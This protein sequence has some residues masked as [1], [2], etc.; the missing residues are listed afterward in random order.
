MA[1][2]IG[3][4]DHR[5]DPGGLERLIVVDLE[6]PGGPAGMTDEAAINRGEDVAGVGRQEAEQVLAVDLQGV[7]AEL[8]DRAA[9]IGSERRAVD[10]LQSEAVRHRSIRQLA[11]VPSAV[12]PVPFAKLASW[13]ASSSAS[14][15]RNPTAAFGGWPGAN[16]ATVGML[17]IP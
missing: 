3:R 1:L 11:A 5:V 13:N 4:D 15:G 16:R 2:S 17:M 12:V 9:A 14:A 6:L 10:D 8:D 7:R